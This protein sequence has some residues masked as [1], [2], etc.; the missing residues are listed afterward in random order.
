MYSLEGCK[1]KY[2][3]GFRKDGTRFPKS[4]GSLQRFHLDLIGS[5]QLHAAE[6]RGLVRSKGESDGGGG[7]VPS[8]LP[9]G[10]PLQD[11]QGGPLPLPPKDVHKKKLGNM[12]YHIFNVQQYLTNKNFTHKV[13]FSQ[14]VRQ[15][16]KLLTA[17]RHNS[18][19]FEEIR[20]ILEKIKG[21]KTDKVDQ[22]F[23]S[24]T[25]QKESIQ[26]FIQIEEARKK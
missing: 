10:G 15:L 1:T 12:K 9:G 24:V 26:L 4:L 19:L 11:T 13:P 16:F 5:L 22:V 25:E 21:T 2:K 3:A 7:L 14:N 23:S 8:P 18:I 20:P 6:Q 17:S